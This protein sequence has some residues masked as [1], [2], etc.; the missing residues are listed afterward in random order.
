MRFLTPPRLLA[1]TLLNY[2]E[3]FPN[4][5]RA[6]ETKTF[7]IAGGTPSE[8]P[9]GL[10]AKYS[11]LPPFFPN[12]LSSFQWFFGLC[13]R[14]VLRFVLKLGKVCEGLW[15]SGGTGSGTGNPDFL[16]SNFL[17][18]AKKFLGGTLKNSKRLLAFLDSSLR[19]FG[20]PK[21][22]GQQ[23]GQLQLFRWFL[24]PLAIVYRHHAD[25]PAAGSLHSRLSLL[26]H[27]HYNLTPYAELYRYASH[28]DHRPILPTLL[29]TSFHYVDE[30]GCFKPKVY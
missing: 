4:F 16:F 3:E 27:F 9:A 23:S 12:F 2:A 15:R 24:D 28:L 20:F 17:G 22:R 11:Q 8:L 6:C 7:W 21:I 30:Y 19:F 5:R 14:E 18:S 10:C 29:D 25:L 1:Q 26:S 13:K